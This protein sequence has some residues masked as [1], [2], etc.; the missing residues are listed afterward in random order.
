[1]QLFLTLKWILWVAFLD[2]ART[3]I[4]HPIPT[5]NWVNTN[6]FKDLESHGAWKVLRNQ[7][8]SSSELTKLEDRESQVRLTNDRGDELIK[9]ESS[10]WLYKHGKTLDKAIV[11]VMVPAITTSA[12][13]LKTSREKHRTSYRNYKKPVFH[14]THS[15]DGTLGHSNSEMTGLDNLAWKSSLELS[16][17][18]H[19]PGTSYR[20]SFPFSKFALASSVPTITFSGAF[21][22]VMI[23]MNFAWIAVLIMCFFRVQKVSLQ[24]H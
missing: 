23:G 18:H 9:D 19:S 22:T 21:A 17:D 11:S 2:A 7:I 4:A 12:A 10:G 24:A 3:I 8:K 6:E 14:E 20:S 15:Y 5:L 13:R 1:M 16:S